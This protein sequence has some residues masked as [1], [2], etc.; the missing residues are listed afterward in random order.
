VV[1]CE[2]KKLPEILEGARAELGATMGG[3]S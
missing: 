1:G 3:V 2:E